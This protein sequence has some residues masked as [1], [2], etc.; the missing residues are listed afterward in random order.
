MTRPLL[1]L[2]GVS[3]RYPVYGGIL[4]HKIHELPAVTNVS[5]Q[6]EAGET[7]GLV[8]ESGCG[9]TTLAKAVVNILTKMAPGVIQEGKILFHRGK[10]VIDL[11]Q[12]SQGEMR[13]LRGPRSKW[14]SRTPTP[15]SIRG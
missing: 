15:R 3:L 8:G 2:Q 5:F 11:L 6:I 12:L 4:R 9:K 1:E 7:L 13:E 10:Q 14:S